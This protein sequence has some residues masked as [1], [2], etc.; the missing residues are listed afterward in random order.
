MHS[1]VDF[2]APHGTPVHASAPGQVSFVG[3]RR[4]YG[5]VIEIEHGSD[6]MT[7]YAH[8]SAFTAGM[9]AGQAVEAGQKIGEVGA[10]GLATG[11]HLHYEVRF[12]GD[13]VD[14]LSDERVV[15]LLA[16]DLDETPETALDEL[17]ETLVQTLEQAVEIESA[18]AG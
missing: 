16:A 15:A 5:K 18:S 4:G 1:G 9:K 11:P 13:P 14:P 12:N 10:T 3:T 8:L 17:R 7:R 6:M 2:A